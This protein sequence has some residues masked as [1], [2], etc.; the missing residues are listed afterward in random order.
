[1]ASTAGAE[2]ITR[3]PLGDGSTCPVARAVEA[4]AGYAL[5]FHGGLTPTPADPRA[6]AGSAACWGN[7]EIQAL[8]GKMDF[9]GRIPTNLYLADVI[10]GWPDDLAT[11]RC[12]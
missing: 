1:M 9:A 7:T 4:P 5:V 11:I 3:Y 8:G 10:S 2:E 6:A 12:G